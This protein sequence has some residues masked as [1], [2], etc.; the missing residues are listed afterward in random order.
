[1]VKFLINRP[2]AVFMATLAFILLGIV[3]SGKIPTS[4]MPDI[5]IPEITV[6]L[7]YP[8]NTARELETNVVRSLRNQLLQV[9]NLKEITSETRDGFATLRLQFEYGTNTNY[10]FIETNE[11]VDASLNY[12]PRDLDRP[13]VIK[14]SATDI[15]ILNLTVALKEDFTD[16]GFLELSEFTETV[17]KKRI[18]QLPDIALADISGLSKPEILVSPKK[19]I[20]QSLG[21]SNNELINAIKQNNF[22]LGNLLVQNGIYQ[23]NFKFANPL[24]S[25]E[26]LEEIYL[27]IHDKLFQLKDLASVKLSAEEDRGLVYSNGKRAIVLSIIKQADARVYELKEALD[28]LTTSFVTDYPNLKFTS[29]Q[30]QTKLLKLSIDN[31]KSSLWIGSL[32]AI[33]IMFFFL[34]DI[35]SPLIIAISIPVSLIISML[36]MFL[37]GLSINII[38]LS[39]LILGVGMMIDNAIIVIDN[40]TQKIES[41]LSLS[42]ACIEGTNEIISPL[43]SSVLTTCSVFLPLLFLS[44][45]TGALFYDQAIAITIGLGSSLVVSIVLIPVVYKQLK[46]K[47][48]KIEKWLKLNVKTQHIDSWYE[49][50]YHFFFERK[51]LVFCIAFVSI[52]IAVI[53]FKSMPYSQLPIINQNEAIV[54]IDW[55]EN[56]H[57]HEN[58]RR[59][60][61]LFSEN[62]DVKTVFSQAGEQQYL[63]QK[64]NAKSFSEATIYI[65]T[66]TI[67]KLKSIELQI[68]DS[69]SEKFPKA[70]IEINPPK[71]IFEYLFGGKKEKLIAQITTRKNSLELPKEND[72]GEIQNLLNG[73]SIISISLKKTAFIEILNE[74]VLLYNVIYTDVINELKTTFNQNFVDNLKTSQKFI[75]I[76]LQYDRLS[77]EKMINH[78]FVKNKDRQLI[79]IKNLIKIHPVNQYKTIKSDRKGEYLSFPIVLGNSNTEDKINEIQNAF[80]NQEKFNI[81]FNGSFLELKA[82][83]NELLIVVLVAV[84]LLYLIMAAQFESLWQPIIILLEIPIDIGG[85]LLLLWLF[86]GTINVMAAIGIVVMSGVVINDSILKLHTI[87]LLR[88]KGHKV[89]EAIKLG[90]KLRLKP[91]LMTSLTTILALMPFLFMDGLGA[92]LQKPL[93]LT[94]IGG[95]LIGTFISLY[96]IP[97]MYYIFSK[98]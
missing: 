22:E 27:K 89:K 32:L 39:G 44:G 68:K 40:I 4:L 80:S 13:K 33:L 85:A 56:I 48:F 41:G 1:M 98:K 28:Q 8:N 55:N 21:I 67:E 73:H 9:G 11:K 88:K 26:D 75:P 53:L 36:L 35:K 87:N 12:L 86:G 95:L 42:K 74:K 47:N 64:E 59:I 45:I 17:L 34:K 61:Q 93:A 16:E 29:N 3:A 79:A 94:V 23:Y 82:L 37:F 65:Q 66:N 54:Q 81:S 91:I 20:L 31:L 49:K 97:L 78:L 50:G 51:W 60:N 58:Q 10:A 25:K 70:K 83:G 63:L 84:L 19:E 57:V 15:P 76:K 5:P 62:Q 43:I 30:D 14:A 92:E 7:S 6:Q 2:V 46:N 96:F 77:F 69:L 24:K 38:S 71:N 52:A 90:G 18:E 72:L